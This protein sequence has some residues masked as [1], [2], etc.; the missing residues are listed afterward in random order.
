M[1]N[2]VNFISTLK[3]DGD[4]YK[5]ITYWNRFFRTKTESVITFGLALL[6]IGY[7]VSKL[8]AGQMTLGIALIC[9]IVAFYPVLVITQFN[10]NIRYHLKHR[11]PC[12]SAPC[13]YSL[14]ENGILMDV[15]GFENAHH[16]YKYEEFTSIYLNVFGFF[17][18]YKGNTPVVVLRRADIPK[19]A[20]EEFENTLVYSANE[21]CRVKNF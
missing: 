9:L 2:T 3:P 15:E 5:K 11:D 4:E 19:D 16:F 1:K 10:S 21:K 8:I 6:A 20:L 7:A 14:M 17:M 13:Q 18:L 12:E